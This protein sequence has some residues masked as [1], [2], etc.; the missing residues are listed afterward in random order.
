MNYGFIS[1]LA[2]GEPV[3]SSTSDNI[4]R[5]F[6]LFCSLSL[7]DFSSKRKIESHW[8][9]TDLWAVDKF[10]LVSCVAFCSHVNMRFHFIICL[11][12]YKVSSAESATNETF[13]EHRQRVGSESKAERVNWNTIPERELTQAYNKVSRSTTVQSILTS[14]SKNGKKNF[15]FLSQS[16]GNGL[17][18]YVLICQPLLKT[19]GFSQS[20]S[21]L[22]KVLRAFLFP[23]FRWIDWIMCV[24]N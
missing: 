7:Y 10:R 9:A 20:N 12:S 24:Y 3:Y 22:P 11:R 4:S 5:T 18:D 14:Y 6:G 16:G 15:W 21:L 2:L 17:V 8:F 19:L 23:P 1:I 13:R